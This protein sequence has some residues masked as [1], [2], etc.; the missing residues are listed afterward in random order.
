MPLFFDQALIPGAAKDNKKQEGKQMIKENSQLVIVVLSYAND[1]S[2][3]LKIFL[4]TAVPS[5]F[6]LVQ[7]TSLT[8][9][10]V[11]KITR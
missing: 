10:E 11:D 2:K 4:P 1:R 9:D 6:S 7:P 8:K 5:C 3:R